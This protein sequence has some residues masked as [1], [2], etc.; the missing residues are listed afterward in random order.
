MSIELAEIEQIISTQG[1]IVALSECA[2]ADQTNGELLSRI[3]AA[4]SQRERILSDQDL[5]LLEELSGP[6][7][8]D[9]QTLI[10]EVIP[11]LKVS[12]SEIM[13]L[14]R[15][16]VEKGGDDLAANQPYLALRKWCEVD[17]GRAVEIIDSAKEGDPLSL[18]HLVFA[19][20]A[21]GDVQEAFYFAGSDG[22]QRS[23]GVL[24]LSRIKLTEDEA[25]RAVEHI[26]NLSEAS[27]DEQSAGLLKRALD[28][29]GKYPGIHREQF[30]KEL[31]RISGSDHPSIVRLMAAAL[32][33][34]YAEMTAG[35]VESCLEG[36]LEVKPQNRGTVKEIDSGLRTIW[37]SDPLRA[38]QAV[39]K[40]I[41]RNEGRIGAD[42]LDG[43]FSA[44]EIGDDRNLAR[45]ATDWLLQGD[46]YVCSALTSH[47]SEINRATPRFDVH[48]E[49]LPPSADEQI[50]LCRKAIGFLFISPMTAASWLVA[51]LRGGHADAAAEIA[52]LLFDPLLLN[53]GGAL[54][55]WLEGVAQV[56][57]PGREIILNALE[58][59]HEVWDG[60]EAARVVVE[61]EPPAS[62]RALMRFQD[63]EDAT[64]VQEMAMT[65]SI[66]SQIVTT[67][68]LLYGDQS[69]FSIRDSSGNRHSESLHMSETSVSSELPKG[70]FFDPVGTEFLI[71]TFRREQGK[72]A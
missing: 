34:H 35:E 48:P 65:K 56:D 13:D 43:F 29:A 28:I 27:D 41:A 21:K 3:A 22:E 11:L 37:Q 51:V 1:L 62:H 7:F 5:D 36:I 47:L 46:F 68:T 18:H 64:R 44:T 59:A 14:V 70:I 31:H 66:F 17:T 30:A 72:P 69:S 38:G 60:L 50:I 53:Y 52:K 45:L 55:D 71:E 24:A 10:C 57:A 9:I 15:L 40:L 63:M 67:Q 32:H 25:V 61:F 58:R 39:A 2:R 4:A 20:Q 12:P 8:F 19:L 33:W 54:K 26:L 49:D 6:K 42:D 16:L 23:A